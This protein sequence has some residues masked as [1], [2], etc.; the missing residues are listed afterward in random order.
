MIPKDATKAGLRSVS[1]IRLWTGSTASSL[2]T[3]GF[4]FVLGL[5]MLD[6]MLSPTLLGSALAMRTLAFL[7]ALPIS[8]VMADRSGA[9]RVIVAASALATV[10]VALV[11]VGLF[12]S[13]AG[14]GASALTAAVMIGALLAGVG[15]GACRPAYQAMVPAIVAT[16]DLQGANA[17]M[18]ISVRV[19]GVLGPTLATGIAV[20][21]ST[22]T[23]IVVI[24]S[25]WVISAVAP[26]R[27]ASSAAMRAISSLSLARFGTQWLEGMAE[28]RQHR[29]F[30]AGLGALSAVIAAGYSVT[31]VLLPL[32][33]A[34]SSH[35]PA[36][37]AWC[38]TAY[39]GGAL[40]AA[41]VISR[42]RPQNRGWTALAGLAL[43]GLVPF[44]LAMPSSLSVPVSA[45]FLAGIGIEIFNVLWFSAIQREIPPD[46]IA[47]VSSLDFLMSY[48]LA[49]LGLVAM[50]PLVEAFGIMPVLLGAGALCMAAPLAAAAVASSR[51]FSEKA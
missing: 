12:A 27:I 26:P 3:W 47:R 38:M 48:G 19:T 37:L 10:G 34:R 9:R 29:W 14:E 21:W 1:F 43:Y 42:W 7:V 6:G 41:V 49:P 20:T 50:V 18:S 5:A 44:S 15:Q 24:A 39:A 30:L 23:A 25:L 17:A 16:D 31:A 46:R 8:G 11:V 45:F 40:L 28:A 36:L 32:I 22:T 13:Q 4:P 33:S 51:A 2:A 35:G